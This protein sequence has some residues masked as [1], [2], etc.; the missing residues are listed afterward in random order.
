MNAA[1][2]GELL[3]LMA[4]YDNRKT[5]DVD[6]IAW[7]KIIGDLRHADC[8]AAVLAHYGESRE[9]IMPADV[10]NRVKE[11]RRIRVEDAEVPAPPPELIDDPP[12]YRAWLRNATIR[13]ADGEE[14]AAI[15]A[16]PLRSLGPA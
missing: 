7:L 1:E 16:K 4:L 3:A 8:E 9:R 12:A 5:G 6:V 14:P 2:A 15:E 13:I 11:A 10:R